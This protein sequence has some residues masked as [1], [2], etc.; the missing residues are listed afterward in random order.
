MVLLD[1]IYCGTSED[2]LAMQKLVEHMCMTNEGVQKSALFVNGKY[3]D[4]YMYGLPRSEYL[5]SMSHSI[6]SLI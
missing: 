6:S 4:V 1:R 2:N 3:K 5:G